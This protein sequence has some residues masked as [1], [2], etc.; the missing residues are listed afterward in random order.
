M[1][2]IKNSS[3]WGFITENLSKKEKEIVFSQSTFISTNETD[4]KLSN[5][6]FKKKEITY[7]LS[8]LEKDWGVIKLNNLKLCLNFN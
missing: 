1:N 7:M 3:Y 2:D 5:Y 8:R 4:I 6:L